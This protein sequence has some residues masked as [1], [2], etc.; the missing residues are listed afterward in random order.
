MKSML[1]GYRYVQISASGFISAPALW[2]VRL[3]ASLSMRIEWYT[4]LVGK[5]GT[6]KWLLKKWLVKFRN[7]EYEVLKAVAVHSLHSRIKLILKPEDFQMRI[8]HVGI[9]VPC[10]EKS[11]MLL[12]IPQFFAI[13]CLFIASRLALNL[14][15]ITHAGL[16]F[17]NGRA[18][19]W[20]C[21]WMD[22]AAKFP[23]GDVLPVSAAGVASQLNDCL[24]TCLIPSIIHV[25][26]EV[27]PVFKGRFLVGHRIWR[28]S[29][30]PRYALRVS[31]FQSSFWQSYT[32]RTSSS[33]FVRKV[34]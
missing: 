18:V 8:C 19:R 30:L 24:Q 5:S 14:E 23:G 15:Y 10:V 4:S 6:K 29:T 20:H 27:V 9:Y 2:I 11:C 33:A 12:S 31:R 13:H 26:L 17:C 22:A 21:R 34:V 7:I 25:R 16:R 3:R 1:R 32:R 28:K